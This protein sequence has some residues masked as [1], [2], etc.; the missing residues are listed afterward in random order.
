M[1]AIAGLTACGSASA[2]QVYLLSVGFRAGDGTYYS[3]LTPSG[4]P[5][6]V[7]DGS[8]GNPA[9]T[10]TWDWNGGTGVLT[11]TGGFLRVNVHA[12]PTGVEFSDYV[13][14]S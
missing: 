9:T 7:F 6:L 5:N 1:L 2:F 12:S 14:V 4:S 11:Q 3:S 8:D 10:A 13:T